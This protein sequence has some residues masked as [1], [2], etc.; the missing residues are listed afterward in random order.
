MKNIEKIKDIHERIYQ[1]VVRVL[2]VTKELPKT[3]QNIIL[4]EQ[5][6]KSATSMGAN[7]QEA[8][9]T[10]SRKDFI[11]KYAIVRK[12]SK[13]T[14]FWLLLISDTNLPLIRAKALEILQEGQEIVAIVSSI[15][16]KTRNYK[17]NS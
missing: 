1:F 9:G 14:N 12:E 6:T 3:P 16:N 13:E 5:L 7:D 10:D 8:D 2:K 4:I 11:A 15:L 17:K